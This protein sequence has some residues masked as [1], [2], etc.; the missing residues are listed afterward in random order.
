MPYS[1]HF[2]E[3]LIYAA[4]L[5]ADQH[6]KSTQV[7]YITHLIS[8]AALVAEYGGDE[9]QVIAA[10]LHDA[11]EDQGGAPRLAEIRERFGDDVAGMVDDCTDTE[12]VPKPPWHQRNE[13]YIARLAGVD[14]RSLLVSAADKLHNVRSIV[15][16]WRQIGDAVFDRFNGGKT[17]AFWYFRAILVALGKRGETPVVAELGRAVEELE[18]L[19]GGAKAAS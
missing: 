6:R 12:R 3:A 17:G 16:D 7:P 19:A 15:A 18:R 11:V 9:H 1:E 2:E 4:R 14:E 5:H 13:A 10:L 8:V